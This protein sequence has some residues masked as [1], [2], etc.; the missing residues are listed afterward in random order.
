MKSC[1]REPTKITSKTKKTYHNFYWPLQ[2]PR[3]PTSHF[4]GFAPI[5]PESSRDW[6]PKSFSQ[7]L[8]NKDFFALNSRMFLQLEQLSSKSW[9]LIFLKSLFFL[10]RLKNMFFKSLAKK[11]R[12]RV[13][14]SDSKNRL[15]LKFRLQQNIFRFPFI[16]CSLKSRISSNLK[17]SIRLNFQWRFLDKKSLFSHS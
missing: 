6:S 8:C 5:L 11:K 16:R 4:K 10:S 7:W 17:S 13:S 9:C 15:N 2:V 1:R 14:A 3:Q 12:N